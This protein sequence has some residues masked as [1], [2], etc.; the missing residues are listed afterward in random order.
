MPKPR[1]LYYLHKLGDISKIVP[2]GYVYYLDNDFLIFRNP[3]GVRLGIYA[4]EVIEKR[5]FKEHLKAVI[6]EDQANFA[7]LRGAQ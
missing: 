7:H 3:K 1:T 5:S 4:I 2:E 6:K